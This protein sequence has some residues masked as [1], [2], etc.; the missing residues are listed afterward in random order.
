MM[1]LVPGT[2]ITTAIR[3]TLNGD[4]MSGGSRA[5]ESVVIAVSI[6]LGVGAGLWL[7]RALP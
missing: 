2:A 3:D 4:Y 1:P 7:W 6:A 5:L